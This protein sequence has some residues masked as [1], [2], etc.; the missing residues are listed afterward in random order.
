MGSSKR[1][2]N[3]RKLTLNQAS[4]NEAGPVA[5]KRSQSHFGE[6]LDAQGHLM[7]IAEPESHRVVLFE[8]SK[9]V[10]IVIG[11]FGE[12]GKRFGQMIRVSGLELTWT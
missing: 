4:A 10:P 12:R 2:A 11:N 9:A 8:T 7:T 3:R 1:L 5:T 6:R